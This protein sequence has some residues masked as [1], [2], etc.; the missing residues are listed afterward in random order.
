MKKLVEDLKI[1]ADEELSRANKKFPLFHSGHEG[2]A[3]LEEEMEEVAE[4]IQEVSKNLKSQWE[5]IRRNEE[6]RMDDSFMNEV[7]DHAIKMAAESI[8]VAAMAKKYVKSQEQ[9]YRK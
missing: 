6:W 5:V 8:Q 1:I 7:Y 3:V 4:E 2:I 9:G